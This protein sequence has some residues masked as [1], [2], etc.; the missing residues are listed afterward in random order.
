MNK[1]ELKI[2]ENQKSSF[3]NCYLL[4]KT[5]H[6]TFKPQLHWTAPD[7]TEFK[8]WILFARMALYKRARCEKQKKENTHG[9]QHWFVADKTVWKF[10]LTSRPR[11]TVRMSDWIEK[12]T[13]ITTRGTIIYSWYF[14]DCLIVTKRVRV[15]FL[16]RGQVSGV[17]VFCGV[18]FRLPAF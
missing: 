16:K 14:F 1:T 11:N 7:A 2:Y 18:T 9:A 17:K 6:A 4:N 5:V 3:S 12:N 13:Y 15:W 8:S 10:N